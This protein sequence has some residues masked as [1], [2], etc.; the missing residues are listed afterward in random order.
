M[1][2]PKKLITKKGLSSFN[3]YFAG[4]V[5]YDKKSW[6]KRLVYSSKFIKT[7]ESGILDPNNKDF[8]KF[9]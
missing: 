2:D 1:F 9:L 5:G 3:V 7:F 6:N 8:T 4:L